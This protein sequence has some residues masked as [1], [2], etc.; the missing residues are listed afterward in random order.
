MDVQEDLDVNNV[1][2]NEKKVVTLTKEEKVC[3]LYV[4]KA[5]YQLNGEKR[6]SE[7]EVKIENQRVY[8]PSEIFKSL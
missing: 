4:G 5:E 1:F 7:K 2:D 8:V 6:L 3:H